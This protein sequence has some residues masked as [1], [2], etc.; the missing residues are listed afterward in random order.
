MKKVFFLINDLGV[1]GAEKVLLDVAKGISKQADV[2]IY[3]LAKSSRADKHTP[4][5]KIKNKYLVASLL[6]I[7]IRLFK[8]IIEKEKPDVVV[9][10]LDL[11]NIVNVSATRGLK[12]KSVISVR[13]HCSSVYESG[14]SAKIMNRFMKKYY[15]LADVVIPNSRLSGEDLIKNYCVPRNKIKVIYN[16]IDISDVVSKAKQPINKE[17]RK[18]FSGNKVIINIGRLTKQK[19]QKYLISA[20]KLVFE[21]DKTV[22][23]IIV[24]DGQLKS[25]LKKQIRKEGLEEVVFLAGSQSSNQFRLLARSQLFVFPSLYEG[26]P[27][28]LLE[29][30]AAKVPIISSDCK[31]GPRELLDPNS[32]ITK[33]S[34][35]VEFCKFGVLVPEPTNDDGYI[36]L[37]ASSM[38]KLLNNKSLCENYA[39]EGFIR[40]REFD[41]KKIRKKFS[42][43]IFG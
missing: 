37:L 35:K 41:N 20:F 25:Q 5:M 2:S 31:S 8:K 3:T 6:P 11:S 13:A 16:P 43:I 1:G 10:F 32:E 14:V 38:S 15:P 26:F 34:E 23:L 7:Y 33:R 30:L 42:K 36:D 28:V 24:G 17:H 4:L 40:A 39:K 12:T 19:G 9:S 27:N 22:R 21:K 18:I 29:A